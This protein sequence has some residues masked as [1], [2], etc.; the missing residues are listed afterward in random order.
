MLRK[1]HKTKTSFKQDQKETY[2]LGKAIRKSFQRS[3]SII[4]NGIGSQRMLEEI[5]DDKDAVFDESNWK[6]ERGWENWSGSANATQSANLNFG[7]NA[8]DELM[9]LDLKLS[10]CS[11]SDLLPDSQDV[12][13]G[14]QDIVEVLTYHMLH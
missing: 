6:I 12:L 10:D 11:I 3:H 7:S 5:A 14:D 2:K 4:Y 8:G 9:R 1:A 13:L